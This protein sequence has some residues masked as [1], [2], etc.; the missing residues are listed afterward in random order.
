MNYDAMDKEYI[1]KDNRFFPPGYEGRWEVVTLAVILLA[2]VLL[3]V[4]CIKTFNRV[5]ALYQTEVSIAQKTGNPLDPYWL[6]HRE[7]TFWGILEGRFWG[8]FLLCVGCIVVTLLH[9]SSF[10]KESRS[11]YVMKRLGSGRELRRRC[12]A[13][14]VLFV[15]SGVVM[16]VLLILGYRA[17]YNS[18]IPAGFREYGTFS[19]FRLFFFF[20]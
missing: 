5:G 11:L 3:T 13:V 14:S 1:R 10:T 20:F 19:I 8:F 6:A 7:N 12:L 17:L 16:M 4:P 15:L 2:S 18:L 9:Y